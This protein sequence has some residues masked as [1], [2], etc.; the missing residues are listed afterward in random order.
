MTR[1]AVMHDLILLKTPEMETSK[2]M[3][4]SQEVSGHFYRIFSW[5]QIAYSSYPLYSSYSLY[6][7]APVDRFGLT[8]PTSVYCT[9]QTCR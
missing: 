5:S 6:S 1:H 4:K 9:I 3:R 8:L 7:I 2:G